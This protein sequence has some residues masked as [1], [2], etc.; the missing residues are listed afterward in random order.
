MVA[1]EGPVPDI[2]GDAGEQ[3]G[4]VRPRELHV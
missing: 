1:P 4:S 2:F 3:V